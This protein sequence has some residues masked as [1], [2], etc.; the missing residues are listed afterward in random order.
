MT[1]EEEKI[2]AGKLFA[3]GDLELKTLKLKC[4]NLCSD[5][6]KLYE[7]DTE[8]RKIISIRVIFQI[9]FRSNDVE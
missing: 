4:H 3:P 9:I 2:F 6:N 8:L 7:N 5:Y 1:K